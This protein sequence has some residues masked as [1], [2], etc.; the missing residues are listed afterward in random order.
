MPTLK[1]QQPSRDPNIGARGIH[2]GHRIDFG[3]VQ[4]RIMCLHWYLHDCQSIFKLSQI[5]FGY[6]VG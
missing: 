3:L 6:K 5:G 4:N 1:C 2:S